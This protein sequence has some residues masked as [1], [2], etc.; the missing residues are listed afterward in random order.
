VFQFLVLL[1]SNNVKMEN[2]CFVT[3]LSLSAHALLPYHI[4]HFWERELTAVRTFP[5]S[6]AK[7]VS[8]WLVAYVAL[9]LP[10]LAFML[11]NNPDHVPIITIF[12]FY[13][14]GIS[15]LLLL[16]A[17]QY[18]PWL[19]FNSYSG[20][21]FFLFFACMILLAAFAL[22]WFIAAEVLIAVLLLHI[23]YPLFEQK[24]LETV[25]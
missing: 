20:V 13:C 14:L 22:W 2:F 16:T 9:L 17:I 12:S 18:V 8:Y 10:E 1:N 4:V 24:P 3:L 23:F 21:V 5:V 7:K 19:T 6:L 25:H 15:H 11:I